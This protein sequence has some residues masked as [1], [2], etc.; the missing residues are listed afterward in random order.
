MLGPRSREGNKCPGVYLRKYGIFLS[1]IP[2]ALFYTTTFTY[3]TQHITWHKA[4]FV[5]WP[6]TAPRQ[7][8]GL[9]SAMS[10]ALDFTCILPKSTD[11][12][13]TA[14]MCLD[15]NCYMCISDIVVGVKEEKVHLPFHSW[16]CVAGGEEECVNRHLLWISFWSHWGGRRW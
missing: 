12:D 13:A 6:W 16:L 14:C 5:L 15:A 7:T 9:C 8:G 11:H 10:I 3:L 4:I 1:T 2:C